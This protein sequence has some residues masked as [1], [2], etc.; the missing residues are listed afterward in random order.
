MFELPSSTPN[1]KQ[2]LYLTAKEIE[3]ELVVEDD[4]HYAPTK[5]ISLENTLSGII[6]P[7]A[8]IIEISNL[9]KKYGLKM[10]LDGA[11]IW[12]VAAETG[13]SLSHLC[14]PFDSVSLC[15]SKGLGEGIVTRVKYH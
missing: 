3:A 2:G 6:L 4:V 15:F 11:R 7:Q 5:V 12:H 14:A 10:H 8:E 13:V 1:H 9:A